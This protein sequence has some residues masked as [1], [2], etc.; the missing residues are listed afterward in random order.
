MSGDFNIDILDP[1]VLTKE[2]RLGFEIPMYNPT[3]HRAMYGKDYMR[4]DYFM[5]KKFNS[6]ISIRIQEVQAKMIKRV[7][8]LVTITD[9][10][11]ELNMDKYET[12]FQEIRSLSNHDPIE[13]ILTICSGQNAATPNNGSTITP[14]GRS[15]SKSMRSMSD[16]AQLAEQLKLTVDINKQ[17]TPTS[18]SSSDTSGMT[19]S[20]SE[21]SANGKLTDDDIN[22]VVLLNWKRM[23]SI[24]Y[25]PYTWFIWR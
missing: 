5:Y 8:D 6:E 2:E 24:F 4:I 23:I 9:G 21:E 3:L 18:S 16:V 22:F 7:P 17:Q 20:P 11:Y 19:S 12:V 15:S 25:I 1:A 10:Q 13:A 14:V